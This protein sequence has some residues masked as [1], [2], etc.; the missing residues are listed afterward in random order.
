MPEATAEQ[1][2]LRLSIGVTV[3]VSL[4]GVVFGLLS[5]SLSIVFDGVF[6]AID[7]AMSGLALF[8]S[9]LVS[10][11]GD[12]RRF[13]FGYW[14]IEPMVLAF[15][16]GTLMLLCFYAFLNAVDSFLAG[17]RAA[18]LRLG[19]RLCRRSSASICFGMFFYERRAQPAHRLG[20]RPARRA[21]LADVG[22]HHLGAAGGV[23]RR[24]VVQG[25]RYELSHALRR[26]GRAGAADDLPGVRADPHRAQGAAGRSC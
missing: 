24:L 14:H 5:G 26:P 3:V 15:N 4:F 17:G 2:I 23:R 7:A 19:D 10:R 16:G 18:R 20:F 1:R 8:V 12:N 22:R 6:S 13:Q 11:D 21:E 25:T 9:R